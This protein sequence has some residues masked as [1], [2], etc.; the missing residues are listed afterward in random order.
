MSSID[1]PLWNV[2]VWEH[3]DVPETTPLNATAASL[4][5]FLHRGSM[6]GWDLHA[7]AV[8]CI[9]GFW[10]VTRSQVYRELAA[11][12][13][14]GLI[15]EGAVGARAQ[16]PFTITDDGRAEFARWIDRAPGEENIRHP[17]LLT[18]AFGEHL[19]PG[20]VAGILADHRR[21][22]ADTLARY[23]EQ[24]AASGGASVFDLA[25]LDFGIRYEQA[26]LDWFDA[27]PDQLRAG[28]FRPGAE[29]PAP[30]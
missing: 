7:T 4:L 8:A 23:R 6:T 28:S 24:R 19:A 15:E 29:P 2:K 30:R 25:T 9:G 16:K 22:H 14:R 3:D 11:L 21:R 20:R 26:T 13:T 10:T 18:L 5:G 12:T 27:L 1:L 17:L